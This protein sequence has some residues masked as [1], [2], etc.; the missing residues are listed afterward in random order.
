M[1]FALSLPFAGSEPAVREGA[2]ST[3]V[4]VSSPESL[5]EKF[6]AEAQR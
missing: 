1:H 3:L 6:G 2:L 4:S 5:K